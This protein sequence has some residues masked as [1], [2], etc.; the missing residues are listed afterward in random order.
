MPERLLAGTVGYVTG[1]GSAV[2]LA[3]VRSLLALDASVVVCGRNPDRLDNACALDRRRVHAHPMDVSDE[4]AWRELAVRGESLA[5]AGAV[6]AAAGV[7]RRGRFAAS[8]VSDWDEM[9]ATNVKGA[10]LAARTFLPGMLERRFGR[11]VVVSSAGARIGLADRVAYSATKGALESFARSLGVE[12]AGSGV[13]VNAVAPGAMPTPESM[14]WLEHNPEL[15]TRTLA[16]IPEGR[17]GK[18]DE[19]EG[20]F[21]FLLTSSYSQGST[22]SVDGGWSVS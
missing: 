8:H 5:P 15:M 14:E 2:G 21:A 17:F 1:G 6:V 19:L 12:I 9:W 4:H 20:A 11:I 16:E 10:M 22:V 7:A 3:A 13:T 18:A